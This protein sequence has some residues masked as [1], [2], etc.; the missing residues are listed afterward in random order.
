MKD[1]WTKHH[2]IK[3]HHKV[4]QIDPWWGQFWPVCLTHRQFRIFYS[5]EMLKVYSVGPLS[6]S[7]DVDRLS[8]WFTYVTIKTN[9]AQRKALFF[10]CTLPHW[11]IE[12]ISF[13]WI[14]TFGPWLQLSPTEGPSPS[15]SSNN[16]IKEECKMLGE[17]I[18]SFFFFKVISF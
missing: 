5:D 3:L 14:C 17:L 16:N 11:C 2:I 7:R 15:V 4:G 8:V 10:Q 18:Q 6:V 13:Y 9:I 1:N 12:V